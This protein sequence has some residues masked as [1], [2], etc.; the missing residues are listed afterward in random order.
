MKSIAEVQQLPAQYRI[1]LAGNPNAGKT[2]LFNA[3]TGLHYK[4]ANYP[5]VTVEKRE[6]HLSLEGAGQVTVCDLP[7]TYSIYGQSPDEI[8]ATDV[9]LGITP[10]ESNLGLI[11]AVVDACQLERNLY[12]VSQLID[13]GL[14]VIVA[15][16]MIDIA[17]KQGLMIRTE[18]LS[19]E[20]GVPVIAIVASNKSGLTQLKSTIS[21]SLSNNTSPR[22]SR[23]SK[24]YSWCVQPSTFLDQASLIGELQAKERKLTG[25]TPNFTWLGIGLL[26]GNRKI[27]P[28]LNARLLESRNRLSEEGID[29]M[30][31]E[32]EARYAWCARTVSLS[33]SCEPNRKNL[34]TRIDKI[35]THKIWGTAIFVLCMS[36]IFQAIFSWASMPMELI[37]GLIEVLADGLS[38]VLPDGEVKSLLIDGILAGVGSVLVFVPQIAI[39]YLFI[40]L[41]EDSGYLARAAFLMDRIMRKFGLQ[42]RSF[43][44]LLSSFACAIPGIMA[45]RTIPSF[46]DRMATIMVAPLMSCSARLP[47]YTLLIAAFIPKKLLLGFFSLQAIV[48]LG[49]YLLGIVA[50]AV[51][52][53]LINR[54]LLRGAPSHLVMEM[55]PYHLPSLVNALRNAWD[56][57]KLFVRDAGTVILACSVILWFLASYPKHEGLS[58][59][60]Q[61]QQSFAGQMGHTIEPVIKPL[62]FDWKIGIAVLASFAAREVFVSSMATVYNLEQQDEQTE[63]LAIAI[64]NAKDPRTGARLYSL[65]IALSLMVFFAF[66]C[67]CMSTVA[68]CYRET[69][70]WKWVTFMITY[71]TTLA[72]LASFVTFR[73]ATHLS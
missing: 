5:G 24:S 62:G 16:N 34:S 60:K 8:I 47:V 22:E 31:Y 30:S 6:G 40:G 19:R 49:L 13:T 20:L 43:I 28:T 10:G 71:M 36:L 55:P 18:L 72:Y 29:P 50:A 54:T 37:E 46:R 14:P 42:G 70:S 44:P 33:V 41:L 38:G 11:V 26:S 21:K 63:P 32:A 35:L 23:G 25:S 67:Q 7:G 65:P 61:L 52:A 27:W 2:T 1:A 59:S 15:L 64:R 68:V 48:L 9:I 56:R 12:L 73:L 4:V 17:K 53:W 66:A 57:V 39:L 69:R 51:V 58:P 3:L 45:T